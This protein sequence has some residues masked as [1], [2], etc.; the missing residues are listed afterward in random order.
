[1]DTEPVDVASANALRAHHALG[2]LYACRSESEFSEIVAELLT[3][4]RSVT[5]SIARL[6]AAHVVGRTTEA[7]IFFA[8]WLSA[9]MAS[10]QCHPLEGTLVTS[11]PPIYS[12]R[13]ARGSE[14]PPF[15]ALS[16]DRAPK[17]AHP[18]EFFFEGLDKRPAL[19]LCASYLDRVTTLVD[20]VRQRMRHLGLE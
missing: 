17:A 14:A 13:L 10:L 3:L 1:M 7:H 5:E 4:A 8:Q 20:E 12:A 6:P 9:R 19:E 11:T 15:D 18:H 2:R 16:I